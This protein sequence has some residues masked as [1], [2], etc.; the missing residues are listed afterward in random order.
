MGL[1][2]VAKALQQARANN[3]QAGLDPGY[4]ACLKAVGDYTCARL[5]PKQRAHFCGGEPMT[6]QERAQQAAA[7]KEAARPRGCASCGGRR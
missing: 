5:G 7:I 6:D 1:Q 3:P 4:E 2:A